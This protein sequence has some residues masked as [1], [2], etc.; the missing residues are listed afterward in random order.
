MQIRKFMAGFVLLILIVPMMAVSAQ[1]ALAANEPV[2]VEVN[3]ETDTQSFTYTGDEGEIIVLYF[4]FTDSDIYD[5]PD[6]SIAG[7]AGNVLS[8]FDDYITSPAIFT[9]PV[10]GEYN[11]TLRKPDDEDGGEVEVKVVNPEELAPGQEITGERSNKDTTFYVYKGADDFTLEYSQEENNRPFT[12]TVNRFS[13][14]SS[15]SVLEA[16]TMSGEVVKSASLGGITGGETYIVKVTEGFYFLFED[17]TVSYT[18]EAVA[19][20]R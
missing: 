17:Y 13:E 2:T 7:P 5:D 4:D 1:D 14:Y 19:A 18:L 16:A 8:T 12:V 15:G 10:D 20:E 3:A 6:L 9:L 11:I